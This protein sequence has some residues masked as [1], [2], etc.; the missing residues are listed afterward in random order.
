M[1]YAKT[2][3]P[4]AVVAALVLWGFFQ[5]KSNKEVIDEKAQEKEFVVAEIPVKVFAVQSEMQEEKLSLIG[6]FKA[7]KELNII[8]ETQGS[9]TRLFVKEGQS[10]AKGQTIATINDAT[11]QSQL[12]TAKASLAK[13][14]KDVE[15]Y[16]NMLKVGAISQVQFEEVKLAMQNQLTNVTSIQQ[17]LK[18][19][20]VKSP[21]SGVVKTV[22]LEEGS[23]ATPGAQIAS[24][25]DINTLNMIVNVDERDIVK[26]KKGQRVQV[27]TE[28][29]PDVVFQGTVTQI[30]V[31][32]DAARKYEIAVEIRNNNQN[33]LKAGMYGQASIPSA[34]K[35]V[36]SVLT[37][38]RKS[39]VGSLK[40]PQVY[41]ALNGKA[42]LTNIEV[43]ET[44]A[45]RVVVLKGLKAGDPVITTG[46]VNLENGRAISIIDTKDALL[47]I[48]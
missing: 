43:G 17:Q 23:F 8:A 32:A 37:V 44:I 9:I 24:V 15:R 4:V 38:P 42:V 28:V 19:A 29:Y 33:P 14:E 48:K 30:S 27:Q 25:V 21:M 5:L 39:V 47:T 34:N 31:Q 35:A 16:Q 12:T 10:V 36:A 1:K 18:Y 2:I 7:R 26:V 40:Q 13:A 45:D 11:L 20:T 3:I 41:L 6:T 22:M 46:Q